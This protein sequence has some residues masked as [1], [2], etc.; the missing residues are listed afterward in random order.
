[1]GSIK[2]INP[3]NN[4]LLKEYEPVSDAEREAA[5]NKAG[6]AYFGWRT[7]KV[8]TRSSRLTTVVDVLE[9]TRTPWPS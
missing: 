1:M 8:E 2:T 9:K 5:I 4:E 6:Q 3:V 7:Y